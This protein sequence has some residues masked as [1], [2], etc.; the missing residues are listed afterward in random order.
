M[1]LK[2]QLFWEHKTLEQLD[3]KEWEAL[4]DGCGLCCLQ[5]LQ[6]EE[7]DEIAY[8]SIS[9]QFL[10]IQSCKCQVYENRFEHLPECMNLTYD[11]LNTALPWLPSTCAYKRVYEGK[12]LAKWHPLV[13]G[14]KESVH[15]YLRSA[16]SLA[17]SETEV[18][19]QDW[20]DYLIDIVQI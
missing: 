15:Q 7:T 4:C 16:R 20:Q 19:E 11:T 9:C 5:K 1:K 12:K 18:D 2:P 3:R 14:N 6:D 8:T 10:D 17:V 13:S